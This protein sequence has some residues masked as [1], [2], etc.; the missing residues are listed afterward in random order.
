MRHT[1]VSPNW[2]P[3]TD[4]P[5]FWFG[6]SLRL[7]KFRTPPVT[8]EPIA[9]LF[10]NVIVIVIVKDVFCKASRSTKEARATWIKGVYIWMSIVV[11]ICFNYIMGLIMEHGKLTRTNI[12]AC[13]DGGILMERKRHWMT[14]DDSL[15]T[16]H[17]IVIQCVNPWS[18]IV[19]VRKGWQRDIHNCYQQLILLKGIT[20]EGTCLNMN[21]N[22]DIPQTRICDKPFWSSC[23]AKKH[24]AHRNLVAAY[25][26]TSY[27]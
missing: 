10:H 26:Y 15:M 19:S 9:V 2:G 24:N 12:A 17:E 18:K 21:Q 11:L 27:I 3:P 5:W 16:P 6:G 1:A 23:L 22:T 14:T 25:V 4:D 13:N 7:G 20:Q 8:S